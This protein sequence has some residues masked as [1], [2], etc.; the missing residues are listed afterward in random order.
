M[1]SIKKNL[2]LIHIKPLQTRA[3][4]NMS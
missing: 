3:T 4:E 1:S 2:K